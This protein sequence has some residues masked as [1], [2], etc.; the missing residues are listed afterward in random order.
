MRQPSCDDGGL[1]DVRERM[2]ERRDGED[3]PVVMSLH[4]NRVRVAGGVQSI[5]NKVH[6]DGGGMQTTQ[7]IDADVVVWHERVRRLRVILAVSL[8]SGV[9]A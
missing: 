2:R 4:R 9:G 7:S 6:L 5:V 1:V 8:S 3:R